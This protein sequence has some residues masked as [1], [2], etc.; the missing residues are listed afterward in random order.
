MKLNNLF[1]DE[2]DRAVS[3]VIGVIL[4]VAITVILAAVIGTFVIGIGQDSGQQTAQAA[5]SSVEAT[6]GGT[7]TPLPDDTVVIEH[8]GGDTVFDDQTTIQVEV[9]GT[10]SGSFEFN[11]DDGTEVGLSTSDEVSIT[12]E[13]PGGSGSFTNAYITFGGVEAYGTSSGTGSGV[14]ISGTG[15]DISDGDKITVTIIDDRSDKVISEL[16]F[17]A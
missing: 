1:N 16:Q 3:P 13:D 17:S 10:S 8:E 12:L 14:D 11:A 7:G 15:I 9:G 2:S 5:F 6:D 4:M